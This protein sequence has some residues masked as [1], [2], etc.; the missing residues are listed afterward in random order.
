MVA[1][2]FATQQIHLQPPDPFDF[3][4]PDDWPRWKRRFEQFR[5]AAG[6]QDASAPKQVNT[7]LYCL[8]EEAE[9]V[10]NST[11]ISEDDRK[12]YAAVLAKFD[13]FFQVRRNI[14]FERA[15]FNRRCQLPGESAEQYIV[16]LYNLVEHCN[17]GTL[18]SEMIR[19][20]L[21]VGIQDASLSQRLQLDPELTLEKAKKLVR[22]R[23]AVQEQQQMLKG[24]TSGDLDEL[25]RGYRRTPSYDTRRPQ[26]QNPKVFQTETVGQQILF[27]LWKGTT[28][29]G[30]MSC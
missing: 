4:T 26:Q 2:C 10:L 21:V 5:S 17:Y 20:R 15:R 18:T 12:D 7:L 16:E 22:Q 19:D 30:E 29:K 14:I 3:K 11:N 8:G 1:A 6:L 9:S 28:L 23:E 24:A 13:G 27:T 25:Q